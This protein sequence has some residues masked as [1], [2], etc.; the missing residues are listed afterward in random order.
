MKTFSM[1]DAGRVRDMNQ[2]YLFTSETAVGNLPNLFIVA[3]GMG[4]HKAGEYA[5]KAAVE[6]MIQS[7]QELEQGQPVSLLKKAIAQANTKLLK[8]A[9][10]DIDK[11]GMGTTIVAATIIDSKLIVANVGD[12]RL[13]LINEQGITQVTRDHSYVEE[14]IRS[15]RLKKADA[16][17]HPHK[18]K[19][20]RAVGVFPS[21]DV[22]F[23]EVE[24][25]K[26]DYILLCTDGL[27]NMVEDEEI[28]RIILGQRDTVERVSALIEEAN[29]NG[30]KDNV[31]ALIIEPFI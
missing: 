12:S 1:T 16:R 15:G 19:I 18:N 22:D 29:K 5:S 9:I 14:L 23:F 13:Y 26:E 28:R 25:G 3:D 21:I 20:T 27:T 7:I 31:T 11:E 8:E 10:I 6:T 24:L 2:D 30:G 4:G 17:N